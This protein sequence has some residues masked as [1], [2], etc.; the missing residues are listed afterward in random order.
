MEV[1]LEF[2]IIIHIIL[3]VLNPPNIP[4][5]ITLHITDL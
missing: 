5:H 1:V 3:E 4:T 2:L